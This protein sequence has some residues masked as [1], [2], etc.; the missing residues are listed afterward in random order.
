MEKEQCGGKMCRSSVC[1]SIYP[2]IYPYI[3]VIPVS[4]VDFVVG[5]M[6]EKFVEVGGSLYNLNA[7]GGCSVHPRRAC[8][9]R[10]RNIL[11]EFR[12]FY[13]FIIYIFFF[14]LKKLAFYIRVR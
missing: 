7:R 8:V 1:T 12:L 4:G 14:I 13:N 6:A 9:A 11:Y 2:S 10:L 3:A 5:I